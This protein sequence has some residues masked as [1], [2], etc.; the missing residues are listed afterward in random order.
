VRSV[1]GR[2]EGTA[3]VPLLPVARRAIGAPL[4][5]R[6]PN[7]P[8]RKPDLSRKGRTRSSSFVDAA[9]RIRRHQCCPGSNAT[10]LHAEPR[11]DRLPRPQP[12]RWDQHRGHGHQPVLTVVRGR[13]GHLHK[14][15]AWRRGHLPT[16]K[17]RITV[18]ISNKGS[19]RW[20]RGTA[21]TSR[22]TTSVG[23]LSPAGNAWKRCANDPPSPPRMS[24][25]RM[26]QM[27]AG[28]EPKRCSRNLM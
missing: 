24:H 15:V 17:D 1:T 2:R 16:L 13:A 19:A 14:A 26:I 21:P 27:R 18:A 11:R 9:V 28:R 5:L 10:S 22:T 23:A 8:K 25:K 7:N 6:L 4:L 20:T 12:R 3:L